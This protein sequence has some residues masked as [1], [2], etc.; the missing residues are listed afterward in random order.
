MIATVRMR[1]GE[2]E[3]SRGAPKLVSEAPAT[4]AEAGCT[5]MRILRA[6]SQAPM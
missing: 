1:R 4:A 5:G 2:A 6:D 3:D